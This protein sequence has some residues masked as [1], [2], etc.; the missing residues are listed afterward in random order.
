MFPLF[1]LF[2][3]LKMP[4]QTTFLLT[5]RQELQSIHGHKTLAP[6]HGAGCTKNPDTI[7]LFMN[8]TGKNIS[9]DPQWM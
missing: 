7:F 6:I 1:N 2:T 3:F 9:A 5:K 4:L 8:P